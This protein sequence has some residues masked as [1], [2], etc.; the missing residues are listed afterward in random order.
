MNTKRKSLIAGILGAVVLSA[1]VALALAPNLVFTNVRGSLHV[2]Q[3]VPCGGNVDVTTSIA[4]GRMDLSPGQSQRDGSMQFD[5]SR[6]E[7]FMT[8]F[9]VQH[10]CLGMT[11][12]VDFR[13]IGVRLAGGVSFTGIPVGS[14]GQYRFSIP[15]EKVLIYESVL[16]NLPVPQ[17]ER[18]YQR[19]AEDVTGLIDLRAQTAQLN[20][21]LY[22][23]LRFRVGCVGKKCLIDEVRGGRQT[24]AA[25]ATVVSPYT[26]TDGDRVPDLQDTCPQVANRTQSPVASPTIAAPADVTLSS[27]QAT[28]IGT[29]RAVDVCHGRP[30]AVSNNA[31]AQFA[32]GRNVV[33]WT[34]RDGINPA[35]TA[36]QIVTVS[37]D[38]RTPPALSC[39]DA[40]HGGMFQVAAADDCA[41]PTAIKLGSYELANGEVI[42]VTET[43][44][45]GVRLVGTVGRDKVRHFQV[46]KGEAVILGTDAAGNAASAACGPV[47]DTRR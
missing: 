18:A 12:T 35:V 11:A 26:D 4:D 16:N 40:D 33:T 34:A 14:A 22:S 44:K 42:K 21:A 7:M 17:P 23:E 45:R 10:D 32:A 15:K 27:C 1:P 31:P 43:G 29:A 24:V 41:G 2:V 39:V 25:T 20:I 28:N 19:P 9:A 36:Q 3:G 38:D 47:V 37:S 46:G 8:P 13:E 6:L 30:V 5:L